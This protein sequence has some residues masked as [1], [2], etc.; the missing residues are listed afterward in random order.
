MYGNN[1]G[2]D[3]RDTNNTGDREKTAQAKKIKYIL[4]GRKISLRKKGKNLRAGC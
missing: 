4:E 1:T 2:K 3:F